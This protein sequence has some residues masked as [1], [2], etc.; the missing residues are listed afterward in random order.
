MKKKL[1]LLALIAIAV[2][3]FFGL[4]LN[5]YLNLD[6]IKSQRLNFLA[7]Y[8]ENRWLTI[9][10]YFVAYV[11]ITAVSFPGAAVM[12]L[13]GGALFGLWL[14]TL[15]VSFA[16]TLGAT[17]AF[18]AARY[19]LRDSFQKKFGE[20]LKSFNSGIEKEGAFYL[21]TLRLIPLVPFFVINIVM[22]LTPLSVSRFFF[23]SQIGML[24]GTLVYVN[25]GTQL[26]QIES[27]KGIL[28]PGVLGSFVILGLFPLVARR[29]LAS[30]AARKVIAK[31]K[32]NKP[33]KYDYNLVVIG[34]G[35]GGL[36]TSYIGAVAKAKVA[37][38]EKKKMGGDCLNQGCVPSKALIRTAKFLNEVRSFRDFAISEANAKFD[39]AEVMARIHQKI[40]M[41]EPHDSVERYS[42]MGVECI[43]GNA[44]I[45][46]PWRVQVGERVLVARN[47]VIATGALPWVP[48]IPG[49]REVEPLTSENLWDLKV[50]P[51]K[52][53][54]LGGGYIGCELALAFAR[55]GSE[56]S[57]VE[58]ETKLLPREDGDVS[59]VMEETFLKQGVRLHLGWRAKSTTRGLLALENSQGLAQ[60]LEFDKILVAL[61]R[62]A[63]VKNMGL[64]DLGVEFEE[65]GLIRVDENLRTKIP[66][67]FACGD[68][69]S[70]QPFT[71]LA[72]HQ[73]WYCAVNAMLAPFYSF[74]VDYRVVPSVLFTDPEVARVGLNEVQAKQKGIAFE[75][76][77]YDLDDLDRAIVDSAQEGFVKVITEKGSDQ[78]LGVT[79]VG[80]HA[81]EMIGEFVLAMK[82]KLGL[83]KILGTIHAYPTFIE[84]NKYVAGIW[85]RE[86]VNA[87]L[88][89]W[90][91]RFNAWRRNV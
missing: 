27:L 46:D 71:H 70:P 5:Q 47:I 85:K 44:K 66:N 34:A 76:T 84:A 8:L 12:T 83:N 88:L 62:R 86:H 53:V 74:K 60:N 14:G 25:A 87:S 17:F 3:A 31:F 21:F 43:S 64:E 69:M 56:V 68:C 39:F 37:L 7:F 24:A 52:L 67:I 11:V 79:I 13:L 1:L 16:S 49:L 65:N 58:A 63:Q 61:G 82:Y 78:I 55:L 15:I 4:E 40:A 30:F 2:V 22:G 42:Q 77:K 73:A 9:I 35:A 32:K 50:L 29:V 20:R 81:G 38:I 59:K 75:I 72:A 90:A 57:L 18:L 80:H 19:L 89:N 6:F 33:K 36:V 26:G 91:E 48:D 10:G 45:L 41:I 51:K 23:V 28:S 54:V